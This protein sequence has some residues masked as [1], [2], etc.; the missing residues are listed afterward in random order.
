MYFAINCLLPSGGAPNYYPNSFGGPVDAKQ[1]FESIFHLSG[2][3]QRYNS[4]DDD[5]FTQPGNFWR[6]VSGSGNKI[7]VVKQRLM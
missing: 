1:Q 2:D 6:K 7:G 5:N 3:V 4:A